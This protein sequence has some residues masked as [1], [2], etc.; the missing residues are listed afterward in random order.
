VR[1]LCLSAAVLVNLVYGAE[2]LRVDLG[3]VVHPISVEILNGAI[4]QAQREGASAILLRLNT[5][6]GLMEAT[7]EL[8]ERMAASPVPVVTWVGPSGARAASAGFFLLLA[9]DVAAMAP[10]T[11]TGAASPVLL[12]REIDPVMRRKVESD[13]AAW[14][15]S[16]ANRRGRNPALAEKAVLE[17]KSFTEQE[18]LDAKLIDLLAANE[19]ELLQKLSGREVSRWDGTKTTLSIA[20]AN[21]REYEPTLRQ[22][23]ISSIAD[24]NIAFILLIAGLLG[25]YI[26]F[27]TPGA[28]APGIAGALLLLFGLSALSV[29][30][31]S[32]LGVSLLLLGLALLL[33]EAFVTSHGVLGIGGAIAFVFGAL[34]LVEG[35]PGVRISF[36][37]AMGVG[38]PFAAISVLLATL[39]VRSQKEKAATGEVG[40][41]GQTGLARTALEPEGKVYVHGEYWDASSPV[42]VPE[43]ARVR[44][45]AVEG[46]RLRVEPLP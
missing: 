33:A 18:A 35:P 2:V 9:G 5:P 12:G 41:L 23:I 17:A 14:I 36:G 34:L 30:P 44:V 28:I 37:T 26:E 39:A 4:A 6:G 24:P 31:I 40:L 43:G 27:S 21:V 3:G 8:A 46:L 45:T 19:K 11:R 38:V 16:L 15:R 32:W 22:K 42:P 10:G 25:L 1:R 20:G 13:A 7:R 29:L